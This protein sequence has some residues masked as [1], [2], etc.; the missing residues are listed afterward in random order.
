M[1]MRKLWEKVIECSVDGVNQQMQ[2]T[3]EILFTDFPFPD[4]L[5]S[6]TRPLLMLWKISF[7]V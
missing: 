5:H 4:C 1:N 6:T 7:S 2:G 3:R